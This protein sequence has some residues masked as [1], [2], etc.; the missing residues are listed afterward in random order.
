LIFK[1][2]CRVSVSFAILAHII[3]ER[4]FFVLQ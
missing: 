4:L 1:E 3:I 2:K